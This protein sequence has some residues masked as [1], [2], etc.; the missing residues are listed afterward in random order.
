MPVGVTGLASGATAI[1]A[2]DSATCA[3]TATGGVK[4]WGDNTYSVIG[5]GTVNTARST[6]VDVAGLASGVIATSLGTLHTCAVTA[7]GA[8]SAGAT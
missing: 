3:I 7:T 6:P 5:D 1:A 2:S 8:S 4:C